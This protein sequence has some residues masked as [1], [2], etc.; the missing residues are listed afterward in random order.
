VTNFFS[1]G[2]VSINAVNDWNTK[3]SSCLHDV[4]IT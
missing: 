4:Q 1:D 2:I 3:R